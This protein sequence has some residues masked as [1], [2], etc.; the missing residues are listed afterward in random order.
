MLTET[1]L[2]RLFGLLG[3]L[4]VL[5]FFA[6]RLS[7]RTR[8]PDVVILITT[9]L[10]LGPVSGW[11]N[12]GQFRIFTQYLGNFTLILILF[13]AGYE[14]RLHDTLRH[15]ATA[16]LFW[17]LGYGLSVAAVMLVSLGVVKVPLHQAL[18]LG[19]VFGCTSSTMVIPVLQ[20]LNIRGPVTV[21]LILE[22]ALGDIVSVISVGR[23]LDMGQGDTLITELLAGLLVQTSVAT[24]VAII[25][26][27]IWSRVWSRFVADR[28]GGVLNIGGILLVYA[29]VSSAGGSGFL[30]VLLFGLTL[31]NVSNKTDKNMPGHEQGI[32][33]FHSDLSFLVRSFFFVLLGASVELIGRPYAIATF[34]ILFGL[35][36]ARVISVYTTS[37]A[38]RNMARSEQEL[39]LCL[40][41][42]GLVNAVLAI[43]VAG[44]EGGMAFLPAIALTVILVTNLLMIL[45][46]F[47]FRSHPT[48]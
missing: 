2:V 46:A 12:A 47:R 8:V 48:N 31:G 9:G 26:G 41:P 44:K 40:F 24:I 22:A 39:I 38:F 5:A 29:L 17:F 25:A 21:I 20:Q 4:L 6:N 10:I 14:L 30:A 43:Q 45:G 3:G 27:I 34:L 1:S 7:W 19:G 37:W 32:L 23:L 15:L 36:M 13:Q 18:L 33:I 42:R 16:V 35:V 11:F 28:F